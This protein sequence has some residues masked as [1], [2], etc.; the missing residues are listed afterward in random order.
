M[1]FT[2]T[3]EVAMSRPVPNGALESPEAILETL[4]QYFANLKG[5]E[6]PPNSLDQALEELGEGRLG[7]ASPLCL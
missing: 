5:I 6:N 7:P 1:L 4:K 2:S 3:E